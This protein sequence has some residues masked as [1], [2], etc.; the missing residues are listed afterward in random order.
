M[1]MPSE[2]LPYLVKRTYPNAA[3]M[4]VAQKVMDNQIVLLSHWAPYKFTDGLTWKENPYNNNSWQLYFQGLLH[5]SY[6]LNACEQQN[7]VAFLNKATWY[8]QSWLDHHSLNPDLTDGYAWHDHSAALRAITLV[9]F[10]SLLNTTSDTGGCCVTHLLEAIR[11][12]GLYLADERYYKKSNH[13]IMQDEALLNIAHVVPELSEA[14]EW[15]QKARHRLRLRCEQDITHSGVHK[16]HS[17]KYHLHVMRLLQRIRTFL[18]HYKCYA[19]DFDTTL[20]QMQTL[21]FYTATPNMQLPLLGDTTAIDIRESLQCEPTTHF[22]QYLQTYGQH[23]IEPPQLDFACADGGLAIFR[24]AW[25]GPSPVHLIFTAAFHSITHKHADDLSF[26]LAVGPTDFLV[27]S[28]S[29]NYDESD[30][31]RK[32]VRSVF[33]HNTIAVD[34]RTYPIIPHLA[35]RSRIDSVRMNESTSEVRGSHSLYDDVIVHRALQYEKHGVITLTDRIESPAE[36]DYC[37]IFNCGEN[38]ELRVESNCVV[39]RSVIDNVQVT[40][41]Q[42]SPVD[43]L[44]Q[45]HGSKDPLRGWRSTQFG[46]IHPIQAIEFQKRGCN[47]EFRTRITIG[48]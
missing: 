34:G 25:H 35:G 45:Y 47:T 9:Y 22:A 10:W 37:Q 41:Q 6:L 3:T 5:V 26:T 13:G 32:Y 28:G 2:S 11:S 23:G 17:P 44:L 48:A 31:Y 30:P 39:M 16:E 43:A 46:E 19:G 36:H 33:A 27:D 42:L 20:A 8:I 14:P 38:V 18:E 24:N 4:S 15:S 1:S 12:H 40:L 7:D 21:L 29:Y